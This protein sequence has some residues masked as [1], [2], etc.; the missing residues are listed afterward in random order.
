VFI[1]FGGMVVD[2]YTVGTH[3]VGKLVETYLHQI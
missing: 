3:H 2:V 1:I